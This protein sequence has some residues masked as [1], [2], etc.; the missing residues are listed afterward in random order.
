M[1][2]LQRFTK[3]ALSNATMLAFVSVALARLTTAVFPTRAAIGVLPAAP[4]RGMRTYK[5]S[6]AA[7]GRT[8]V[9]FF[10]MLERTRKAF[11]FCP[12][13]ITTSHKFAKV[14]AVCFTARVC[15]IPLSHARVRAKMMFAFLSKGLFGLEGHV[16]VITRQG[17]CGSFV[18]ESFLANHVRGLPMPHALCVAKMLGRYANSIRM[19][20]QFFIAIRAINFDEIIHSKKNR[21]VRTR[22]SASY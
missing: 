10:A 21:P 7:L 6:K 3:R 13:R 4:I 2:Y 5:I 12:A 17:N 20:K 15:G 14:L 16:A 1:M 22:V 18:S 9:I 19:P 8:K 11:I